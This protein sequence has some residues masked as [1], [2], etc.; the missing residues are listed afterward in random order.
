VFGTHR[1]KMVENSHDT[2]GRKAGN[3]YR[4]VASLVC[5]IAVHFANY[6][7]SGWAKIV[8]DGGPLSW[9]LH[10]R[11][12]YLILGGESIGTLPFG[13]WPEISSLP[14]RLMNYKHLYIVLNAFVL[15]A[16]LLCIVAITRVPWMIAFTLFFDVMHITIFV[17]TGVNFWLWVLLN[18]SIVGACLTIRHLELPASLRYIPALFVVG[19]VH[20]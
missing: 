12:H 11:T 4:P 14:Y 6:F 3:T 9:V 5:G 18:S 19:S 1:R 17:L 10:N 8:L 20:F 15:F 13:A 2:G 7:M 16:Q